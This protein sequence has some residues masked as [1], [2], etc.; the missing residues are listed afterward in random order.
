MGRAERV[1]LPVERNVLG[2]EWKRAFSR[3]EDL[4]ANLDYLQARLVEVLRDDDTPPR[5]LH[6]SL[7]VSASAPFTQRLAALNDRLEELVV[8]VENLQRRLDL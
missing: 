5:I 1:S 8:N 3:I 7:A 4:Q 2:S 6:V